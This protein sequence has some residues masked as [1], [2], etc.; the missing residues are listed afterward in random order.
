MGIVHS[1][2]AAAAYPS[3]QNLRRIYNL[4]VLGFYFCLRPCEYNKCT[5]H[6]RTVKFHPLLE[7]VIYDGEDLTPTDAPIKRLQHVT[8][9]VLTLDNQKNTIRGETVSHLQ[10]ESLVAC[11]LLACVNIFL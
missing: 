1:I 6:Y 4:F 10:L 11:A 8:H 7:F 3:Y 9:I 2:V 5:S